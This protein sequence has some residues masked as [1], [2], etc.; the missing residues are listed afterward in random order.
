[1]IDQSWLYCKVVIE[2]NKNDLFFVSVGGVTRYMSN[3]H[4]MGNTYETGGIIDRSRKCCQNSQC[5]ISLAPEPLAGFY[6][7]IF[8][9]DMLGFSCSPNQYDSI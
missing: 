3:E 7:A 1:M 5:P 9:V 2:C 4:C 6:I 8:V